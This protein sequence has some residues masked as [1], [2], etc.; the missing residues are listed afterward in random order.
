MN[1][2]TGNKDT[3]FLIL[4]QLDDRT[5][6]KYCL[7]GKQAQKLCNDERFWRT[8][9]YAKFGEVVKPANETW[10]RFYTKRVLIHGQDLD[11]QLY[12]AARASDR[13]EIARL[14]GMG[15][16]VQYALDGAI[17]TQN[18]DLVKFIRSL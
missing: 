13:A 6:L 8:R 10:R 14:V 12:D 17:Y 3:D 4:S 5:L 9:T 11:Q 1:S 2:L 7:T 15:A 18:D 16:D